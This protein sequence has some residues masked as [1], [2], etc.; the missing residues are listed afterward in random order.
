MTTQVLLITSARES[1][2]LEQTDNPTVQKLYEFAHSVS[3]GE[4]EV[5]LAITSLDRLQFSVNGANISVFDTASQVDISMYDIVHL[6]GVNRDM[7]FYAD[8]AT[9]V[10]LYMHA[11]GKKVVDLE[12]SG[13]PFGK[14]SQAMLFA[15]N[16]IATPATYAQWNGNDLAEMVIAKGLEYPLIL[17]ASAGTMGADNYLV[18]DEASLRDVLAHTT[19]PFVI[20]NQ[21]PN[22]GDYRVLILG[23]A[24]PFVFWRPRIEGSHLSNTSQ[25][26][27]PEKE[28]SISDEALQLALR[29]KDVSQRECVGVDLMQNNQTGE[30]IILEA[31]S[32]PA[33]AT[34]AF[35]DEKAERYIQMINRIVEEK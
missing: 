32:N 29:A 25:G 9:A 3:R 28:V 31:N 21:I 5:Q 15:L 18:K 30:W 27:V 34:G 10:T 4:G 35:N 6:R 11:H 12:D 22:D 20:Q 24:E 19:Q 1:G 7:A 2:W 17:K 23:N 8:F 13:A 14:L 33:L 26:S 16:N